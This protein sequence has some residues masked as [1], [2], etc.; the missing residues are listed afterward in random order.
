[1]SNK[2]SNSAGK[3]VCNTCLMNG[4]DNC[5]DRCIDSSECNKVYTSGDVQVQATGT[6][7]PVSLSSDS[8]VSPLELVLIFFQ[9][10]IMFVVLNQTKLLIKYREHHPL[11]Y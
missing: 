8:I 11:I 10:L 7:A 4:C 9:D 6:T 1:M 5:L 2:S 3:D